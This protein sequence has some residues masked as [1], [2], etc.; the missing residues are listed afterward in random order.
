MVRRLAIGRPLHAP[1]KTK[2]AAVLS[3]L[4]LLYIAWAADTG[5]MPPVL[6]HLYDYPNGDRVGHVVVYG[7]LAF[8][9]HLAFPGTRQWFRRPIPVAVASLFV[10]GTAEEFSQGLFPRRTPD[11]IDLFCTWL[12]IAVGYLLARRWARSRSES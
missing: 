2:T 1:M 6:R 12:G 5:H 3:V 4:F 11:A 10:F 8:L 9:L 7:T